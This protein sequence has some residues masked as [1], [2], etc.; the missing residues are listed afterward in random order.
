MTNSRSALIEN[1]C[2]VVI[3]E[4]YS[5]NQKE[6]AQKLLENLTLN[7]VGL[8]EAQAEYSRILSEGS[9]GGYWINKHKSKVVYES[10]QQYSQGKLD[11]IG[12]CKM[13]SS[14]I[15]HSLIEMQINESVTK[16]ELGIPDLSR[17]LEN[18]L[19]ESINEDIDN[20]IKDIL[21]KYG[22]LDE[23]GR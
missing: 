13:I 3:E 10:L 14:L 17:A 16:E 15:T 1:V 21:T 2:S 23:E 18:L 8:D 20:Q 9:L 22:Y 4:G 11:W 19:S 6:S 12:T 7:K 5:P